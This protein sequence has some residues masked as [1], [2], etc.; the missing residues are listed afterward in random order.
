MQISARFFI[1]VLL[2]VCCS[3]LA[4]AV[5]R[6]DTITKRDGRTIRAYILNERLGELVYSSKQE[7]GSE[8]TVPWSEV[9]DFEYYIMSTSLWQGP[10]QAV[11]DGDYDAAI[12]QF[13]GLAGVIEAD[14]TWADHEMAADLSVWKRSYGLY[15]LGKTLEEMGRREQAAAVFGKLAELYP[16]HRL[17]MYA[18]FRQGVNAALSGGDVS[19]PRQAIKKYTTA[20]GKIGSIAAD[21]ERALDVIALVNDDFK[22]ADRNSLRLRTRFRDEFEDW[23]YWRELWAGI[24]MA[25]NE[26]DK[27][28]NVYREMHNNKRVVAQP[29]HRGKTALLIARALQQLE[30]G[31]EAIYYFL[32]LDIM[33]F[34]GALDLASARFEAAQ[35]LVKRLDGVEDEDEQQRVRRLVKDLLLG[36]VEHGPA[37]NE[38]LIEAQL[39]HDKLFEEQEAEDAE[40]DGDAEPAEGDDEGKAED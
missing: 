7:G 5:D 21:L 9:R 30:R 28:L 15:Y 40:A 39:L 10:N 14:G 12:K 34:V 19:E 11:Y 26:G 8:Q 4:A 36:V 23:M 20:G 18:T 33:P 37:G 17:S 1:L 27:A 13:A 24:L 29:K 22:K 2:G 38:L 32:Q 3:S 31:D 16:E 35:L 6:R 25:H